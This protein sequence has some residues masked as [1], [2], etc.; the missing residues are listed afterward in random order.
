M[1]YIAYTRKKGPFGPLLAR[2]GSLA[3]IAYFNFMVFGLRPGPIRLGC[4]QKFWK[5]SNFSC[6]TTFVITTLPKNLSPGGIL[7][8]SL[9]LAVFSP[10]PSPDAPWCPE[11]SVGNPFYHA[12]QLLLQQHCPEMKPCEW[13]CSRP[14]PGCL[15]HWTWPIWS[16][17]SK[18]MWK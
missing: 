2:S 10:G 18:N 13:P 8:L 3:D 9:L 12:E 17:M 1:W 16:W 4:P 14:Y 6:W 5:Q 11:A 7:V 15:W